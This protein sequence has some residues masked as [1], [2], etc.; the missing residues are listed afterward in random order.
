MIWL[1]K[2]LG[3]EGMSMIWCMCCLLRKDKWMVDGY[4][5]TIDDARTIE[6]IFDLEQLEPKV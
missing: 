5:L 1:G 3:M 4:V 6:K 2:L